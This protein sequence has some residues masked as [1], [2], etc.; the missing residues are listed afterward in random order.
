MITDAS[1]ATTEKPVDGQ[2]VSL[3]VYLAVYDPSMPLHTPSPTIHM[4]E[5]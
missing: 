1:Q 5:E 4:E 2:T 3:L